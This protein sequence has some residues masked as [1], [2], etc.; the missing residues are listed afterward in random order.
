MSL[1]NTLPFL[2]IRAQTVYQEAG[3]F[4][5]YFIF[6]FDG[7]TT[8][9]CKSRRKWPR[10]AKSF[11]SKDANGLRGGRQRWAGRV[12]LIRTTPLLIF[13]LTPVSTPVRIARQ[14]RLDHGRWKGAGLFRH[15]RLRQGRGGRW[16][17]NR[18]T[19]G[20]AT[21]A[22]GG[23]NSSHR[24]HSGQRCRW[25]KQL[26]ACSGPARTAAKEATDTKSPTR[27][28]ERTINRLRTRRRRR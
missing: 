12:S 27:S 28:K 5:L 16:T 22:T 2:I 26:D 9:L 13:R 3:Y 23:T 6:I 7:S 19:G 10:W 4:W 11:G 21:R 15:L 25:C 24:S 1:G 8:F 18:A 20:T 14:R 17:T